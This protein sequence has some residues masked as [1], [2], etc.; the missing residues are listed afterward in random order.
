MENRY[1]RQNLDTKVGQLFYSRGRQYKLGGKIG[2]GA[3][4]V[5]RKAKNIETGNVIAVKF[6]AP[7]LKYIEKDSLDDIYIR[8]QREGIRGISLKHENLVD[9]IAFEENLKGNCFQEGNKT[10][11]PFITME[12]IQGRTLEDHIRKYSQDT[13]YFNITKQSLTIANSLLNAVLY[14][15]EK[16]IV[17]R[18]IKPANIF[19]SKT[20]R[21][22]IPKIIKLGDFGVVKWGDFKSSMISGTLTMSG[23]QGLG[24]FKYMSPEQSVE[25]K[26]VTVRSD[27]YSIGIT[28]FELFTNQIFHT[29]YHVFQ[30]STQRYERKGNT[31]SHL[32]EL[33]LGIV[34]MKYEI[35]FS[36][37]YD[38]FLRAP[39]SRPS[40]NELSGL[41][42][43]LLSIT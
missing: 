34:P 13:P 10:N 26:K 42:H 41:L 32:H 24:T 16:A 25:P 20:S 15:H 9:I 37:L 27:M 36:K 35:L 2:D 29:P 39:K 33:G 12:Y 19:L 7:E 1:L 40:S 30:L 23:Y 14:L 38:T 17:H 28:L 21:N 3:I 5:V 22:E 11:N 31:I 8:F 6:L 4:G 18:D 43:Y